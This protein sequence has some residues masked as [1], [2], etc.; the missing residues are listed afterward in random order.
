MEGV[1]YHGHNFALCISILCC[2]GGPFR[3]GT[4]TLTVEIVYFVE[5]L[6]MARV[7]PFCHLHL[8]L[9]TC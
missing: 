1:Y 6:N 5:R 3:R 4:F 9:P 8:V 7:E 2:Q